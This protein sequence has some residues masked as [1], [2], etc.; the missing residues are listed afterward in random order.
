MNPTTLV[1]LRL[2]TTFSMDADAVLSQQVATGKYLYLPAKKT[3]MIIPTV[4]VVII[5]VKETVLGSVFHV[6]ACLTCPLL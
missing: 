1:A 6:L 4:D 2:S 5:Q 3:K